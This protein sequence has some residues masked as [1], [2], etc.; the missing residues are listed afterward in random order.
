MLQKPRKRASSPDASPSL[1][2]TRFLFPLSSRRAHLRT[3]TLV[4]SQVFASQ[5]F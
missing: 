3:R 4:R 5:G 1:A 2:A